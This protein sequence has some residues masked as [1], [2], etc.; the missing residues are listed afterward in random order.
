MA[1]K[2]KQRRAICW[3][4]HTSPSVWDNLSLHVY[5]PDIIITLP[6]III[7]CPGL[8]IEVC[9]HLLCGDSSV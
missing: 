8:D 5:F 9:G 7:K 1:K 2:V 3:G 4:D 6:L